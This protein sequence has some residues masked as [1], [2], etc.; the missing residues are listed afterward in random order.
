MKEGSV[1]H[2]LSFLQILLFV[3]A[4]ADFAGC[5]SAAYLHID[6]HQPVYLGNFPMNTAPID[7]TRPELVGPFA[8]T[9][10][11]TL[12]E[13]KT[14]TAKNFSISTGGAEGREDNVE[15][16]VRNALE[17]DAD[18]YISDVSLHVTV[19]TYIPWYTFLWDF[20]SSL[21]L[22]NTQSSGSGETSTETIAISGKVY[23]H[24]R[25]KR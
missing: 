15:R 21:I 8:A 6:A 20:L 1:R 11:H 10:S 4:L 16:E 18:R 9:T 17:P 23:D 3:F 13:E 14:R 2:C 7:S 12:E 22:G 19:E 5:S 25:G 24:E